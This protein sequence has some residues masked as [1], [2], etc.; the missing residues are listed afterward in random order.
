MF[1]KLRGFFE[2]ITSGKFTASKEVVVIP[3]NRNQYYRVEATSDT[4]PT[5][6]S[7]QQNIMKKADIHNYR[8]D[9]SS[10]FTNLYTKFQIG[11]SADKKFMRG[12]DISICCQALIQSRTQAAMTAKSQD[13]DFNAFVEARV[14][15]T[16]KHVSTSDLA[17]PNTYPHLLNKNTDVIVSVPIV[18]NQSNTT[19]VFSFGRDRANPNR[20]YFFDANLKGGERTGNC[21]SIFKEMA[22]AISNNTQI[23][24]QSDSLVAAAQIHKAPGF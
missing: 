18:I 24:Y 16:R 15:Y 22:C 17:T 9:L 19:H 1:D 10:E 21:D 20:C 23:E 3:A 4:Q 12:S 11:L 6:F 2:G 5:D 14:P 8:R 7:T 13:G